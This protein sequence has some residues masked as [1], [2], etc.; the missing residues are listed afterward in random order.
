[1]TYR[2][3][4][5]AAVAAA[6]A[7]LTIAFA[8]PAAAQEVTIAA[9]GDHVTFMNVMTPNEGVTL[10]QLA[11]QLTIA[12]EDDASRMPGFQTASVHISRD[13]SYVVNYAQWDDVASVEAVVAALGEGQLPD[14]AQAFAMSSPE[15]H[16]YDVYSVTLVA[17]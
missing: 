13:D 5:T 11:R 4:A 6:A 16:P 2:I 15:F 3:K 17:E 8:F 1:M 14:L 10:E 7:A 9:G 12:M